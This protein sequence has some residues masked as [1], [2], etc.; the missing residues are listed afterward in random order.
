M[1]FIGHSFTDP[2]YVW[3]ELDLAT[4]FVENEDMKTFLIQA[5]HMHGESKRNFAEPGTYTQAEVEYFISEGDRFMQCAKRYFAPA[6]ATC[7]NE[8]KC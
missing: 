1:S 6:L 7:S 2:S 4:C 3:N 8:L 5:F